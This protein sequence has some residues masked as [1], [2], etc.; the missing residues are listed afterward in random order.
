M[1]MSDQHV[2]SM[3]SDIAYN[4]KSKTTETQY[5]IDNL[6]SEK[7]ALQLQAEIDNGN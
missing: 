2:S 4:K 6:T 3:L 5:E 1:A 7:V